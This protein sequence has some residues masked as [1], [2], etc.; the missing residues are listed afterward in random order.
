M[1][2]RRYR[3]VLRQPGVARVMFTSLVARAPNGMSGLAILLLVAR[4]H[5]YGRAGLVTGCYVAA[6]G[7]TNPLL[8]RVV[9]RVGARFVLVGTAFAYGA[10]MIVLA[11]LA[12]SPARRTASCSAVR[13]R[14]AR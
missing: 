7:A 11:A 5:G 13:S 8:S 4:H 10:A 9:D 12:R 14:P 2:L 3:A 1:P 6:A